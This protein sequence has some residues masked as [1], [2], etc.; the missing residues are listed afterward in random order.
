MDNQE[1]PMPTSA[2]YEGVATATGVFAKRPARGNA[3]IEQ[4]A[5]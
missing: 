1:F 5:P 3:W 4:T 2:V